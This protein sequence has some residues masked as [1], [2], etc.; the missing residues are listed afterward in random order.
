MKIYVICKKCRKKVYISSRVR[1]RK[2]LPRTIEIKC[3][4]CGHIDVYYRSE[5]EAEPEVGAVLGGAVL[6]GLIGLLGGPLGVIIGG[7]SGGI[8][9]ANVDAEEQ[10]MVREFYED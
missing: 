5:V 4:Y 7:V 6:G 3:P 1:R 9:G 10:R 8:L 2:D